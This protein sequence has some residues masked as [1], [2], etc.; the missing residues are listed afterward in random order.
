[1]SARQPRTDRQSQRHAGNP[2]SQ[3]QPSETSETSSALERLDNL[4]N[5]WEGRVIIPQAVLSEHQ[6]LS[7]LVRERRRLR[8]R[9]IQLLDA[10]A[11]VEPGPLYTNVREVV[12]C[13]FSAAKLTA[14]L[15]EDRVAELRRQIEP[16]IARQLVV[17]DML[18]EE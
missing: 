7:E 3:A 15:G 13:A 11:S 12:S 6:R 16:T 1:M 8:D 2:S 10:G 9:L 4:G 5:N 18:S 14:I 17:D